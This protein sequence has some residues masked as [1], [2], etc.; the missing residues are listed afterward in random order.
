MKLFWIKATW[1]SKPGTALSE[2]FKDV[3]AM[4]ELISQLGGRGRLSALP[5]IGTVIVAE[6]LS[7]SAAKQLDMI[8]LM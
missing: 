6:G 4:K 2:R 1:L 7:D 5:I 3:D 8:E